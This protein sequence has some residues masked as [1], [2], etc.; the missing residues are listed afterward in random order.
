MAVIF[1]FSTD[2]FSSNQ[3]SRF[4]GP[5]LRWFLPDITNESVLIVQ[6]SVRKTAHLLEYAIL[7]ILV[8]RAL[9]VSTQQGKNPGDLRLSIVALGVA[10]A[11]ACLDEWHQSWTAN[12]FGSPVDVGID[13]L[14]A[15][16]GLGMIWIRQQFEEKY[17]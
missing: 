6:L 3:T 12:R 4:I 16:L 17:V 15:C 10:V 1:F 13:S 7:V 14:G 11:Y 2:H 9:A 8:W 5:L